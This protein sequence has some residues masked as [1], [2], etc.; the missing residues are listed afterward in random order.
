MNA[1][2]GLL[3]RG[4]CAVLRQ[5]LLHF[6]FVGGLLYSAGYA[7]KPAPFPDGVERTVQVDAEQIAQLREDWHRETGHWPS[8]SQLQASIDHHV[9]DEILLREAL[10]LEL[11]VKD[12]VARERLLQ[13]MRFAFPERRASERRLLSEARALGMNRRDLIVRRRL[14][15][16]MAQRLVAAVPYSESQIQA[17]VAEQPKRYGTQARYGFEHVFVSAD[18]AHADARAQAQALYARLQAGAEPAAVMADPFL[19]GS[20]FAALESA[21]I[22]RRFGAEFAAAV[23]RAA[24]GQWQPPVRSPYGLHLLRVTLRAEAAAPDYAAVRRR[25]AYAWLDEARAQVLA[26]AV[27][28]LRRDYR[29]DVPMLAGPAGAGAAP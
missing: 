29:I 2:R 27:Q 26:V 24:P 8:A 25:A 20:A 15:Q 17:Y 9:D 19:L 7:L 14:I 18:A 23:E 4:V 6:L 12:A 5:P 3:W 11:D 1:G 16:V 10:R 13:N 28:Q 21:D 22:E